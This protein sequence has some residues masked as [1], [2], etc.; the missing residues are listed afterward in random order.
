M[1]ERGSAGERIAAAFLERN[2]FRILEHN[3]RYGPG[4]I[5][6]IADD[7]GELVFVEVKLRRSRAYG[8]PEDAITTWKQRT[9]RRTA[10]GYLFQH[11]IED[12]PCRFDVVAI[13]GQGAAMEIRHLRN[14]F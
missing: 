6:L 3:Y 4:E 5:D 11:R 13:E 8:P 12:R 1:K 7:A 14:A 2:G 9:L 10:E